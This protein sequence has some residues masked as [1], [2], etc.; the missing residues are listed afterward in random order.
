M[1]I[2]DTSRDKKLY[3]TGLFILRAVVGCFMLSHGIQKWT[4]LFSVTGA[5]GFPDPLG[6]G[7]NASL[8]LAVFAEV[9]CSGLLIIGLCTRIVVIPL[10]ITMFV[11]VFVVHAHD[12]FG[13]QELGGLYLTIYVLL[14]ITGSGKYSIDHFIHKKTRKRVY[15]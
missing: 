11:A 9:A 6:V 7:A 8:A 14:L 5:E 10:I 2:F 4:M 13:K 12:G 1:W 3:H 15:S